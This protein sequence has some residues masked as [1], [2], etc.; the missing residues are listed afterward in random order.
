MRTEDI[1][2]ITR[3]RTKYNEMKIVV[4]ELL[5][6]VSKSKEFS[7]KYEKG[8]KTVLVLETI[9]DKVKFIYQNT[10]LRVLSLN[11]MSWESLVKIARN[12]KHDR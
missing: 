2:H 7:D 6:E 1:E 3:G 8:N 4:G 9:F 11:R 12:M 10:N 5:H